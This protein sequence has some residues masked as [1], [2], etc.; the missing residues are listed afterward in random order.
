MNFKKLSLSLVL[1][2]LALNGWAQES[3][4]PANPYVTKND[5]TWT[6]LGKN[7]ND[8]M[9]IGNG[10]LAANVWTEQNGDLLLLVAKADAWSELGKLLKLGRLRIKL[11]PNPFSSA[12]DFTQ[13]L[14][15]ETGEIEIT[16]GKNVMRVWI[17][18]NRPVIHIEAHLDKPATLQA[19]L[20]L[21]RTKT[22]PYA[23]PSPERGGFFEFGG[24]PMPID[25]AADTILPAGH[26]RITWCHYNPASIY[27]LV[28]KEQH[29]ESLAEKYPDPLLH[30]CFG[31][32]LTGPGLVS[33]DDQTLKSATP[34]KDLR[35]DLYALT[36]QRAESPKAWQSSLDSLVAKLAGENL[37]EALQAHRQWWR[38]FWGRSWL[39]VTGTPDAD[40]ISQGYVMQRWMLACSS[41]GA[42]PA[43]FNG[44]LFTVGRDMPEGKDSDR[45][46]HNPDFREWGSSFWNQN[47]RL[48][49]WPL[50]ATGDQDLLKPWFDMYLKALPLARDR[51]RLYDKHDGAAF[52]ETISF[53]GLPNLGDFGWGNP[54][55]EMKSAWMR[56]HTQGGIEMIAQ[57]LD[58]YD[59]TQ[60]ADFARSS[61]AP[62]AADIVTYYDQHWPRNEDGKIKMFP[63]QSLETYQRDATNPT[64]DI[65]GL[66][67]VLPRLLALPEP[68][69]T[70]E[71]RTLWARVLKDL[72]PIPLGKTAHGKLPPFGQGD[73]NGTPVILPAEKY[74]KTSNSENPEL[75]AAFPYPLYGVGKPDLELARNTFA[76]RL[77]PQDTCWGQDGPQA[78]I[79][80]LTD[81]AKTAA[82]H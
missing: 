39:H 10:D 14:K 4:S 76:A 82:I 63:I 11:T 32:T 67:Y 66:K 51:T 17:D 7:E 55:N 50:I 34:G 13:V 31:A 68:L 27:P 42:Q 30:R 59:Y 58:S 2:V 70:A 33:S 9:P 24:V 21:W 40:K 49:Y 69:T 38:D 72:P 47:N 6:T 60:E 64:P 77:F 35:V 5:V 45:E 73:A 71:Q 43:K 23:D 29:L 48:L 65:A 8:S 61:L 52:I 26:D 25:F 28:L 20:E 12:S 53:W 19:G 56:F 41:R 80:G 62:F 74:G 79:L 54:S 46:A 57:M 37:D 36:E 22:R 3:P 16:S 75:Y 44:G 78:A 81:V 18:V 1:A 15:L